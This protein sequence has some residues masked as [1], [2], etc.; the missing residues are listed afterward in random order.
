MDKEEILANTLAQIE[1]AYGKGAVMRLGDES[2][3]QDVDVISTGSITL[4]NALGVGGLPRGRIVEVY[5]TESS[6]KTTLCLHL[7]AEAQNMAG[8]NICLFVDAEHALDPKWAQ[9]IGVNIQELH[10]AQPNSG[11]EA[12]GIAQKAVDSGAVDVI[13]VDSV[14]SLVP[15]RELDGDIGDS[16][17]GLQAR[18]MS[19]AMRKLT[20][21]VSRNNCLVVFINQ[22]REKVGVVFGSPETTPGGRALKFYSSVRLDVRRS[23]VLTEGSEPVGNQVKIKVVKNKVAPPHRTAEVDLMYGEGIS[24]NGEIIDFGLDFQI[25]E[26]SG[27]WHSYKGEKIGQGRERTKA[28]LREK[29]EVAAEIEAQIREKLKEA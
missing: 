4:D 10:I 7:I 24:K 2:I 16:H 17:V 6:G 18:L 3:A 27:A 14:A 28:Y 19:Q 23:K 12:L 29:P 20:G 11:E 26:R 22:I 15:K 21:V 5:G 9:T 1:S 13:V 25:L 8:G